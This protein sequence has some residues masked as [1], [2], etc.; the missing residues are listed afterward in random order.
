MQDNVWWI[1][2]PGRRLQHLQTPYSMEQQTTP[3]GLQ[4]TEASK[5]HDYELGISLAL[6]EIILTL[7]PAN[8][9]LE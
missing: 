6:T 1:D 3:S 2:L 7:T 9:N 4:K 8:L 5:K